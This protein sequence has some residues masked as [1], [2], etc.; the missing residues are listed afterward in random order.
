[1]GGVGIEFVEQYQ[2][3]PMATLTGSAQSVSPLVLPAPL[4]PSLD[5]V[6]AA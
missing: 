5:D 1:M 4:Q 3:L 2:G 6:P